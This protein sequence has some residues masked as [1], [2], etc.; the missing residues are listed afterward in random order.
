MG[1]DYTRVQPCATV[2]ASSCK[3]VY[4]RPVPRNLH[5]FHQSRESHFLTFSCYHRQPYFNCP[6]I[7]D[8]FL[9]CLEATRRRADLSIYGYVIMPEHVHLLLSEPEHGTL[10]DAMRALKLSFSKLAR[11]LV[12]QVPRAGF[13][14]SPGKKTLSPGFGS[15]WQKRYYDRN[16]RDRRE[17]GV[18]LR[19]LHR[20]PVKRGLAKDL[21]DWKWSSFRHYAFRGS[22]SSRSNRSGRREIE[23]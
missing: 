18:K 11:R 15:F 2:T 21:E 7:Y 5:R 14:S 12:P 13:A 8:L 20:N 9:H 19:Y 23:K 6:E 4:A 16:V 17:F 3:A 22:E 10:A 1:R